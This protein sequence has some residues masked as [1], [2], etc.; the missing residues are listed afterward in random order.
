MHL[1]HQAFLGQHMTI[2]TIFDVDV[3]LLFQ[4]AEQKRQLYILI[5]VAAVTILT[6]RLV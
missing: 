2:A 5:V 3:Q 1:K 6:E 4:V